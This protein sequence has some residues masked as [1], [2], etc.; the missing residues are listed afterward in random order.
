MVGEKEAERCLVVPR[1]ALFGNNDE[2]AFSGFRRKDEWD[3]DLE[4]VLGKHYSFAPRKTANREDDVEYKEEFKQIIPGVVFLYQDKI[5]SYARLTG[6]SEERLVGRNDILI[7][8][9]INPVDYMPT[10]KETF[11]KAL[12]R[13]FEEEINYRDGYSLD[14]VG[15]VN[16]DVNLVDKVH[17]GL[18][19]IINGRS[20][21]ISVRETDA[22]DGSLKSCEEIERLNPP[23]KEWQKF[24]YEDFLKGYLRR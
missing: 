5:F 11:W 14:H 10:F 4:E 12:H 2:H 23:L 8:G 7:A 3:V 18:V 13:E 1:K 21:D 20:P 9:H 19:Y 16:C 17:F 22:L 15:Y 24:V 6:S